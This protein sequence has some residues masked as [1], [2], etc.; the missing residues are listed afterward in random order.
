VVAV[1]ITPEQFVEWGWRIPFIASAAL[2][3]VGPI[4]R[5][6]IEETAVFR[7]DVAG[8]AS[9]NSPL[10]DLFRANWRQL[11]VTAMVPTAQF[12]LFYIGI[13]YMI[14]YAT[15]TL[16]LERPPARSGWSPSGPG[17]GCP[18]PPSAWYPTSAGPCCSPARPEKPGRKT[19]QL[20]FLNT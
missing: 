6:S 8:A 19:S 15:A 16:G 17:R 9:N 20:D 2:I 14:S 13:T 10:R 1:A 5:L 12:A 7:A 4:V 3:V 11:L 18:K